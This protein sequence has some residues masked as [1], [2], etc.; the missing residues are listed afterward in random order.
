MNNSFRNPADSHVSEYTL[1]YNFRGEVPEN[2]KSIEKHFNPY[3]SY[4]YNLN[5]NKQ[6]TYFV[7]V[8]KFFEIRRHR[9]N[10]F[11]VRDMKYRKIYFTVSLTK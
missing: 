1:N 3:F 5:K 7:D 10:F 6:N 4:M 9:N 8:S 11:L 2:V